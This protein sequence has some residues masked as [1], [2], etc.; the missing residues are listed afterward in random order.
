MRLIRIFDILDDLRIARNPIS[1]ESLAQKHGVSVRTIYRDMDMLQNMG[2]PIR[3][4]GGLGYQIEG[5]FFLPPLHFD[6]DELD[7]VFFGLKL[8]ASRSDEGLKDAALNA[9]GKISAVLPKEVGEKFLNSPILAYSRFDGDELDAE[10][11]RIVRRAVHEKFKIWAQYQA[12]EGAIS[13]RVIHPLGLT[14][15]DEAWI[16]T[17]WCEERDDFRNFRL[18]RLK[19]VRPLA[20]KFRIQ[21]GRSFQDY[22]RTL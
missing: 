1:A 16:L 11:I 6:E 14:M 5:G 20:E 10:K 4:E 18:D 9:L 21:S 7:A 2:A 8:L 22:L 15:F 13:E 12:L 17:A 3:G 19:E